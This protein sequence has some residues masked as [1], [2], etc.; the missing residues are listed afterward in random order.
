VEGSKNFLEFLL[1]AVGRLRICVDIREL[2]ALTA[3]L[4]WGILL[5]EMEWAE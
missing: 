3:I 1:F 5:R 2:F 4:I